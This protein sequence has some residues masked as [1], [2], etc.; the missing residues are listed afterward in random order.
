[1]T[2]AIVL[3]LMNLFWGFAWFQVGKFIGRREK[4]DE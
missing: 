3:T 1:M 2:E 4:D